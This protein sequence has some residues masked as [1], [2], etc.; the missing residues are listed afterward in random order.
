LDLPRP[1][2]WE[3]QIF[4]DGESVVHFAARDCSLQNHGYQKFIEV[5]LHPQAIAQEIA[6]LDASAAAARIASLQRRQATL[7]RICA[8]ALRL[9][10]AVHLRGAA[11]VE[12]LIDQQGEPYFLEV[13]PRIQVEHGVT[14]GIVRVRG[15]AISLVEL[16]QRV[17]AGEKLTFH[18]DDVTFVGDAIEVRLNA[19]HE[20]L[21]PV[22]GGV[23]HKL[24]LAPAPA[25]APYVR[26]DAGGLLQ[27]HQPWIVPSYDA[28]FALLIVTGSER[29]ETLTRLIAILEGALEIRGNAELKTN[30]QPVLGLLT[31]MR[32]LPPET[33]F[34]TDTSL[35]WMALTAVV[36]MQQQTVLSQVPDF[37]RRPGAHDPALWARLLRATLE[38]GFAHP[39]RLLT[40]YLKRLT[41]L[42]PRPVAPLEVLWQLATELAVPLYEEERAQGVAL[43][44]ASAALWQQLSADS[45]QLYALVQAATTQSLA[46]SP[47]CQ[48]VCA[49]LVATAPGLDTDEAAALLRYLLDWLRIDIPA[50]TALVQTL[51]HTHIHACL[52]ANDDLSLTRPAYLDDA[53]T[54]THLQRLLSSSLR[55]TLLRHGELLS[56]MEATIYHHPE[57]GAPPFVELGSEIKVGQTLALLEAMKMFS[58]LPSPVDGVLVDILVENGQGVKTG[59]PLFRIATQDALHLTADV[60]LHQVV[61]PAFEN[62]FGLL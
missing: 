28:N 53:S 46:T 62:R 56:P 25:L 2:H 27:R 13:N 4:G 45:Q 37:P 19:W 34:R 15:Q 33:E 55:P 38:A 12:F 60:A 41:C 21:S 5:A 16:Q 54:M 17:A 32:A 48:A 31:L 3:V 14:E 36:A 42:N 23:V 18:Q 61:E 43:L 59:T 24:R 26:L 39:S 44:Q 49:H 6:K 47:E 10:A 40:Y 7:E 51:E 30:V 52:A 50:I 57:P 35:L 11:T 8:D 29:H 1:L 20:D 9:G 22:L 58:E